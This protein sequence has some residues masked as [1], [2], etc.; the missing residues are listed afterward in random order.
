M[1]AIARIGIVPA[2]LKLVCDNTGMGFAAVA[3]VTDDTW[4]ACAVEDRIEFGLRPGDQ[5]EV[6]TTLCSEARAQREPIVIDHA[7]RDPV[8]RDH[9]TPR[10]YN[11]QSYISVPII[12][13]DGKYFGNLCAID[14]NPA[15]VS[16]PRTVRMFTALADMIALQLTTDDAYELTEQEVQ[17]QRESAE[18]REQFIA[19]LGHD[20]RNPLA[21]VATAGEILARRSDTKDQKLGERLRS[22]TRRMGELIDNVLDFARARLGSGIGV[23][24]RSAQTLATLLTA[25]VDESRAVHPDRDIRD[26]IDIDVA[27]EC[28]AARLQQLLSNLLGNACHHGSPDQPVDVVVAVEDDVL[29]IS[30]RN[31]GDCI[32]DED[33]RKIFQ[34]YWRPATS[35]PGGGLGL[36]LYIC[37]EIVKA[38]EGA[39]Q[40]TSSQ[41][42]GTKFT[43]RIPVRRGQPTIAHA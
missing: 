23:E 28:D 36:G 43:A 21:A 25:V 42:Q 37:S 14:P 15:Q 6:D 7:S 16:E 40:A 9:H 20:L 11:I 32:P 33:L 4:T 39:L 30:V 8:Y 3:R 12:R 19:V 26:H 35:K 34:P 24:I 31:G 5:L 38:H 2:M 22:S 29:E 18:L 27:V 10:I 41:G 1:A 13:A 17:T